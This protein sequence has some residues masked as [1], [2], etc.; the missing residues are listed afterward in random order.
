MQV[1]NV[2]VKKKKWHGIMTYIPICPV[3][4]MLARISNQKNLSQRMIDILQEN[5]VKILE[6]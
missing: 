1:R 2:T 5:G 4:L 6:R 3:A